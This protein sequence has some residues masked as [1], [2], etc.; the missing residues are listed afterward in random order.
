V[1]FV[2]G[3][4]LGEIVAHLKAIGANVTRA[5]SALDPR[6]LDAFEWLVGFLSDRPELTPPGFPWEKAA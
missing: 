5:H 4:G 1:A 2:P 6:L 3:R